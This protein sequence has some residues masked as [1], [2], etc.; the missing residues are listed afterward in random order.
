VTKK[1]VES[2]ALKRALRNNTPPL[3]KIIRAARCFSY[4]AKRPFPKGKGLFAI[5]KNNG[6]AGIPQEPLNLVDFVERT[7]RERSSRLSS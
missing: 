4:K 5:R 2:E 1:H 3:K 7:K 6:E